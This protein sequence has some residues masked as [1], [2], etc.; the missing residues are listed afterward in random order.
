VDVRSLPPQTLV[1][2]LV[3]ILVIYV[4]MNRRARP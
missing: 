2:L 4:V 3:L 1:G